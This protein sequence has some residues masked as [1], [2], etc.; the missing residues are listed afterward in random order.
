MI[1]PVKNITS[2]TIETFEISQM[3]VH[4]LLSPPGDRNMSL[5]APDTFFPKYIFTLAMFVFF[6]IVLA[7]IMRYIVNAHME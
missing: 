7:M 1:S 6:S 5:I 2:E 4:N 3:M